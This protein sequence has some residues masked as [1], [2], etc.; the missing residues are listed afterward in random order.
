MYFIFNAIIC[1][2]TLYYVFCVEMQVLYQQ[3]TQIMGQFNENTLVK[4]ELDMLLEV[5]Q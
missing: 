4:G 5:S 3:K 1:I 2:I